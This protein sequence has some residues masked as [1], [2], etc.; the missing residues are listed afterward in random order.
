[1]QYGILCRQPQPETVGEHKSHD[2]SVAE[3]SPP[4]FSSIK[5][6]REQRNAKQIASQAKKNDKESCDDGPGVDLTRFTS[7]ACEDLVVTTEA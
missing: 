4:G 6:E 2:Q 5:T 1:M 3:V 7:S